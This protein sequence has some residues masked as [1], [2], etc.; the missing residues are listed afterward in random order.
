MGPSISSSSKENQSCYSDSKA[1]NQPK[2]KKGKTKDHTV[3]IFDWDDTLM[4]TSFVTVKTQKL[5]EEEQNIIKELGIIVSKFLEECS[6]YGNIIIMTNSSKQWIKKT[7]IHYLKIN[8]NLFENIIIISTRDK[9]LKKGIEKKK[10]K[11][12]ELNE[13]LLKYGE[14]IDNLICASDSEKDIDVFKNISK[15]YRKI[16]IST[17]KF[18]SNPSPLVLIKEIKYLNE[19]FY[20]TIGNNKNYYLIKEKEKNGKFNFS[21]GSWLDYIFPN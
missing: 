21:L 13:I 9:Y 5:S 10:W 16:N 4:C 15:N 19:F 6:K 11:E 14:K 8:E 20:E 1:L 17:I 2:N 12:I 18:K 7:A 3:F